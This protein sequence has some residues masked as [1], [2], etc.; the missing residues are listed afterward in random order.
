MPDSPLLYD[1]LTVRQHLELVTLSHGVV[2]DGV[3]ARIDALLARL[4][5]AARADF[6][7]RELSRGMR[8]KTQL[9]CALIR[10]AAVL[11]LD[12]PVVGL[13][14][15]SQALLRELLSERKRAGAAVLLTT[16]QMAFADGLADR[17]VRARGGRGGRRGA[18][19]SRCASE[20]RRAGGRRSSRGAGGRRRLADVRAWWRVRHPPPSLGQRLDVAYTVAIIAAIVGALAYGTASSALAQVVTPDWLARLGPVARARSRCWSATHWGAYQGPVVFSV[21]DVAFLLGAPLPRR[22]LAARRLALALAGGAAAGAAVAGVVIVGLAGEGRGI[23]ARPRRGPRRR[24]RGARACSAWRA[25]GRSSARRAGSARRGGRAWPAALAAAE[26]AAVSGAGPVGRAIALWSG[27]WGWAVQP[28]AGAGVRVARGAR[29]AHARRP[30]SRRSPPC[31]AA[32]TARP[33]ATCAAPRRRASAVASLAS[34]DARTARRALETVGGPRRRRAGSR[35]LRRVR[36]RAPRRPVARRRGGAARAGR[37]SWRRRLSRAAGPC[38][39][40]STADRPV[41]LA[42]APFAVYL[43]AVAHALAAARRARRAGPRA[44]VLLRPRLGRVL[45]AHALVPVVVTTAAAALAR[46]GCALAGSAGRPPPRSL[47]VAVAPVLTLCAAMSARRGGRLPPSV[48]A[49]AIAADPSG[50]A[51][52]VA[53][54]A[55]LLAGGRHHP[56]RRP[57][58]RGHERRAG[59]GGRGRPLDGDRH[60]RPRPARPVASSLR[61]RRRRKFIPPHRTAFRPAPHAR[62][63]RR[64]APSRP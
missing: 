43:G 58:D 2:D 25:P 28:G 63:P 62:G 36:A 38:S 20:R 54:L 50:G 10:P 60:R 64:R 6:L 14:P 40:C 44:R 23:A 27:P 19:G 26:L 11:V 45:L 52:A 13:D 22:G 59:R 51:G 39:P 47:A 1:D 33:S 29:P 56:R 42:V 7:P 41:A 32:A 30:P 12:E 61:M 24:P 8:Q 55:R 5:L 34:F 48:L 35:A 9:A 21:A 17:A 37:G 18:V 57:A 31:A 4:G 53:G 46:A 16:H 15:P 49:T 3:D